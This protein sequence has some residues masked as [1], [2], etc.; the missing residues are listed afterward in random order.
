MRLI[1]IGLKSAFDRVVAF[2]GL[3]ILIPVIFIIGFFI[4]VGSSGPVFFK[5]KRVGKSEKFFE[6]Y[7]FRSMY[8]TDSNSG[9]VLD[10]ISPEE[11]RSKYKTTVKND[12]RITPI[13]KFIRKYYLDELPQLINVLKGE[14]S[15]VGPRPYTPSEIVDYKLS[16]WKRR[17]LVKPGITGLSQLFLKG[18]N[19]KRYSRICLDLAYVKNQSF[20]LDMYIFFYTFI[21]L[22]KGSSF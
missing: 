22:F 3:V 18:K 13:G 17:H 10:G 7:K 4:K 14:M 16:H 8:L 9:D 21:K 5:Q 19:G 2:F 20:S 1:Q 11:A 6:I 12:P 15:L